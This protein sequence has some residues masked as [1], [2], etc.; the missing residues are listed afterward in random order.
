MTDDQPSAVPPG[1]H[2]QRGC[3]PVLLG[4]LG[5]I[6]LVPGV[7]TALFAIGVWGKVST[8]DFVGLML[9]LG[10]PALL[11]LGV[12]IWLIRKVFRAPPG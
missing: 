3:A 12:G 11:L 5:F 2:W 6:L 10:V 7:C 4:L 8:G 1:S 9:F